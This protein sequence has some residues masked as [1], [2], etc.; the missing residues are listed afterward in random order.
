MISKDIFSKLSCRSWCKMLIQPVKP[1]LLMSMGT[2]QKELPSI[3]VCFCIKGSLRSSIL[4]LL[5]E[6]NNE[7]FLQDRGGLN[8]YR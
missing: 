7:H 1:N 8:I 5:E 6:G 3:D 2:Q 4:F